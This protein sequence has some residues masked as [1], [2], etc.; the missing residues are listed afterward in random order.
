LINLPLSVNSAVG[1]AQR[2]GHATLKH[3]VRNASST[4]VHY[5]PVAH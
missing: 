1:P 4:I 5:S 3:R 2:G